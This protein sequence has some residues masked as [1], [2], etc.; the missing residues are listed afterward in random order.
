M[1]ATTIMSKQEREKRIKEFWAHY[2]PLRSQGQTDRVTVEWLR[3]DDCL[4]DEEYMRLTTAPH[5]DTAF[6][7]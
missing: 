4:T 3:E 5:T 1:K 6:A 7:Y 2:A